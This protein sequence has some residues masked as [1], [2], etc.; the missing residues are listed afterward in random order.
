M[1]HGYTARDTI[2]CMRSASATATIRSMRQLCA[3]STR[4]TC[5]WCRRWLP[6]SER[7]ASFG[8]TRLS[9][10]TGRRSCMASR[11]SLWHRPL[12]PA[13]TVIGRNRVASLTDKGEGRGALAHVVRDITDRD[14]GEP[15]ATACQLTFLRG[16]GGYSAAAWAQRCAAAAAARH[17][18]GVRCARAH[19]DFE[20]PAASCVDLP[21]ERRHES[22]ARGP[23]HRPR[24]RF[25]KADPAWA[26]HI[27]HGGACA[28]RHLS[29]S[30]APTGRALQCPGFSR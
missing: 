16:E 30:A 17:R 22:A 13:A 18:P 28:A 21:A 27:R 26:L 7:P 2:C 14:S 8:R 29:G 6:C 24:G 11:T 4:R 5:R 25:R 10:W 15:I 9:A 1:V 12:E 20:K 3:S 19:Q 23:G